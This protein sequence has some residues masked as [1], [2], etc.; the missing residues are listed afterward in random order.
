MKLHLGIVLQ[1]QNQHQKLKINHPIKKFHKFLM[2]WQDLEGIFMGLII[3]RMFV[4][5]NKQVSSKD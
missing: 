1:E 3:Y 5:K 4:F 2:M